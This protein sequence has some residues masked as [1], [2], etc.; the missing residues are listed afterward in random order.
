[1]SVVD[2]NKQQGRIN[3]LRR[4]TKQPGLLGSN[5][6]SVTILKVYDADVLDQDGI[7]EELVSRILREPGTLW[8]KVKVNS[9]GRILYC[10][11]MASEAE[12]FS[13][14]GNSVLLEGLQGTIVYNGIRPEGGRIILRGES[15]RSLQGTSASNVLDI[16]GI[17]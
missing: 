11:F 17:I 13:T 9:G 12:I 6:K 1:M 3:K 10:G 15:S 14:H 4:A 7:P 5:T 8:G 16:S 2:N